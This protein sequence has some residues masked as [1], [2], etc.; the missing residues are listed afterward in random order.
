MGGL[1]KHIHLALATLMGSWAV[2]GQ[3]HAQ[4]NYLAR[5]GS[6]V[7]SGASNGTNQPN[8]DAGDTGAPPSSPKLETIIVTAQ[9]RSQNLQKVSETVNVI[10][11]ATLSER[12]IVNPRELVFTTPGLQ[13]TTNVANTAE[14]FAIRGVGTTVYGGVPQSVPAIFDDVPEPTW[15]VLSSMFDIDRVEI[16]RG[17]QGTLFGED[18]SS[19]LVHIVTKMP[20]LNKFGVDA[21]ASYALA[22]SSVTHFGTTEI[23]GTLNIPVAESAA[24]RVNTHL[25]DQGGMQE[26]LLDGRHLNA[27]K[28]AGVRAKFLWDI[29]DQLSAYLTASYTHLRDPFRS[30]P[31]TYA[32]PGG[33]FA[34]EFASFGI[35]PGPRSDYSFID[36]PNAGSWEFWTAT[37]KFEWSFNSGA[38][39][40]S[41]TGVNHSRVNGDVDADSGPL[42]LFFS[43]SVNGTA[44]NPNEGGNTNVDEELR[45]TSSNSDRFKYVAGVYY[46]GSDQH[47]HNS[48][49]GKLTPALVPLPLFFDFDYF[50]HLRSNE[51]AAYGQGTY[52]VVPRWRILAGARYTHKS[53][54]FDY[55][56]RNAAGA[57]PFPGFPVVPYYSEPSTDNNV[58][59]KLGLEHD[60]SSSTMVYGNA[61]RGYKGSGF[62][63]VAVVPTRSQFVKPEIPTSFEIGLKSTLLN[64]TL[65]L[66]ADVYQARYANY[67]AQVVDTSH[68][69]SQPLVANAG[70]LNTHGVEFELNAIPTSHLS[71]S[72]G[73]A[74]T[75][76]KYEDFGNQSCYPGQTSATGCIN[77]VTSAS[78]QELTD[79][80]RWTFTGEGTYRFPV[81]ADWAGYFMA[82]YYWR[83]RANFSAVGAP[84][85]AVGGYGV[86]GTS[87]GFTSPDGHWSVALFCKNLFDKRFPESI[88]GALGTSFYSPADLFDRATYRSPDA[89]RQVG[90]SLNVSF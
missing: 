52:S 33:Y 2:M 10:T 36:G 29:L 55:V 43:A 12:N 1:V 15:Y 21:Y 26:N 90:L 35:T 89:Y 5:S 75:F 49:G 19:G 25:T 66:N 78:G 60:I 22:P 73:G 34:N 74:Y 51:Y 13:I 88:V 64:R 58:S 9:K 44:S 3:L 27:Y 37:G 63:V 53:E 30:P 82:N 18:S 70:A 6:A 65:R 23:Q 77:G 72:A 50:I 24:L 71:L 8:Q 85:Q 56:S 40:A 48:I 32:Q 4:A 54:T 79:S 69:V 16:L 67:Q 86:A 61:S 42:P 57:I 28:D 20:Q 46:E 45:L 11:S 68:I 31:V 47:S 39:L 83:S 80:P 81:F 76:A 59:W 14:G 87:L 38:T 7:G 41:I 17:P 84:A 62:N